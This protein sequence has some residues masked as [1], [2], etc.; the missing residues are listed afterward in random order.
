RARSGA[1]GRCRPGPPP[2][3]SP[4]HRAVAPGRRRGREPRSSPPRSVSRRGRGMAAAVLSLDRVDFA[5]GARPVLAGI[6]ARVDPGQLVAIVGPN[7]AGKS[8][9]L[10]MVAGLVAPTSGTVRVFDVDPARVAR[11]TL[12]RR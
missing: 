9:L 6:S 7:G 3:G 4:V 2:V 12:A 10:R 8:T 11:R 1:G 5:Y